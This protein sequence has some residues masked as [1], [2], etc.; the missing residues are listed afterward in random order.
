[1]LVVADRAGHPYTQV[2]TKNPDTPDLLMTPA[3]VAGEFS[4]DRRTVARWADAGKLSVLRTLGGQRR[5]R[6][7]EV[8]ELLTATTRDRTS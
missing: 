1:M 8:Q 3:E 2:M 6:R 7:A 5:Y 4:V